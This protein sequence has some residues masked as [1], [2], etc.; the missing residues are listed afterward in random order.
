MGKTMFG[1]PGVNEKSQSGG[2]IA[3]KG[4]PGSTSVGKGSG[5]R[6]QSGG[7]NQKWQPPAKEKAPMA[8][9][10]MAK[11]SPAGQSM[12]SP[13]RTTTR[14][15]SEA[16]R[17]M[18]GMPALNLPT[19]QADAA[20][21]KEL[22]VAATAATEAP[23]PAEIEKT[24]NETPSGAAESVVNDKSDAY[25]ATM[26]GVPAVT[27]EMVQTAVA[28][29]AATESSGAAEA[30]AQGVASDVVDASLD[31]VGVSG[32]ASSQ[33]S[34]MAKTMIQQAA[35]EPAADEVDA[36]LDADANKTDE[37]VIIEEEETL[38]ED[39]DSAPEAA[40][41]VQVSPVVVPSG[42]PSKGLVVGLVIGILLMLSA[43]GFVAWKF[44]FS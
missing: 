30:S 24:I 36:A 23:P 6:S 26:L 15:K 31:S 4:T 35:V 1:I 22:E 9:P 14:K 27:D 38:S 2:A 41:A 10:A 5:G 43:I 18:F 11:P 34:V 19:K 25:G 3:P 28:E 17:T 20:T 16:S 7:Q 8:K 40:S 13:G 44:L 37:N 33:S 21:D 12:I 32:K 39:D 42:G 29:Q